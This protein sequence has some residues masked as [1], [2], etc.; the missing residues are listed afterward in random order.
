MPNRH[1]ETILD[2]TEEEAEKLAVAVRDIAKAVENEYKP[3]G[4]T[5]WQNNGVPSSQ[6]IAHVHFHVAGTIETGGTEWG[7][8]PELSLEET[9]NI[10]NKLR[11][12]FRSYS[13]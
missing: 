12:Y 7:D 8:V 1:V 9:E 4:I 3:K 11:L 2:V 13:L 6:S 10:A 5:I